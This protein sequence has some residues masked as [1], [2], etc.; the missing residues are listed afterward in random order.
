MVF[1]AVMYE[2]KYTLKTP[3]YRLAFKDMDFQELCLVL[4]PELQDHTDDARE[5]STFQQPH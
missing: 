5:T 4:K 1:I 3:V 2:D